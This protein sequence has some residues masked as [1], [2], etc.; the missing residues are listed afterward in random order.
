MEFQ[1]SPLLSNEISGFDIND[2]AKNENYSKELNILYN[3]I[4]EDLRNLDTTDSGKVS[5]NSLLNYL[6]SKIPPKRNLNVSLFQNLFE[7]LERDENSDIDLDDFVKKYIQAHEE[8][9]LNF[10]TLKKGFDKER[11][12][13]DGLEEKIQT[14][15]NETINKNGISENS[16]VSTE[17]GKV[18]ILAVMDDEQ[19]DFFCSVSIDNNEE[20]KTQIKNINT[21]LIFKEKFTFPIESKEKFLSYKIYSNSNPENPLGEIEVPLFMLNVD[22]EE[23]TPDFGFKNSNKQTIAL[24]KPKIIIVTSFYDMYKKQFDNI[25]RNIES[26]QSKIAQLS[27]FLAEISLPY[28]KQFDECYARTQK[29]DEERKKQDEMVDNIENMLK[30][31]FNQKELYW[32]KIF[33]L[34]IYFCIFTQLFTSFTKPDF[35]SLVIEIALAIII[36]TKMT[37]YLYEYYKIFFFGIIIGICYD[38]FNFLFVSN[39]EISSMSSVNAT[40]RL[41]GFL[42]FLGKIALLITTIVLKQKLGKSPSTPILINNNN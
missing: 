1:G 14:S 17:I 34:I 31:I 36:N 16:C 24:F 37:N 3:E 7:D 40:V 6:Q 22:N 32:D 33:K 30:G 18:T 26:Y 21:D 20:K 10:D 28:K 12:I 11:K 25:E 15:K 42:G 5:A 2:E 27:E 8:L 19:Q 35:I 29:H 41:F 9:K 13:K 38:L 39:I 4:R 23:I